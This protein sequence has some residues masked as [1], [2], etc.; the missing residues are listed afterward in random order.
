MF[1]FSGVPPRLP[2]EKSLI[3]ITEFIKGRHKLTRKDEELRLRCPEH[4]HECFK[5]NSDGYV[6]KKHGRMNC[7]RKEGNEVVCH[8]FGTTELWYQVPKFPE[9]LEDVLH[10]IALEYPPPPNATVICRP[11]PMEYGT[12]EE[13]GEEEDEHP[14]APL[15]PQG[16]R[17][18]EVAEVML[19][20][21]SKQNSPRTS[22]QT[23]TSQSEGEKENWITVTSK[24]PKR[25]A[26]SPAGVGTPNPF[27]PIAG[28]MEKKVRFY[29]SPIMKEQ[30][31][32]REIIIQPRNASP[33]TPSPLA[34]FGPRG[35]PESK[36]ATNTPIRIMQRSETHQA[37][38][39]EVDN[40][41]G[42]LQQSGIAERRTEHNKE[43]TSQQAGDTK[44]GK[45]DMANTNSMAR[46]QPKERQWMEAGEKQATRDE[47]DNSNQSTQQAGIVGRRAEYNKERAPQQTMGIKRTVITPREE[48]IAS[49]S[50]TM[51][52]QT[53]ERQPLNAEEKNDNHNKGKSKRTSR[54]LEYNDSN[55]NMIYAGKDPRKR[56]MW[57][58]YISQL[59]KGARDFIRGA[60]VADGLNREHLGDIQFMG[61]NI[62]ILT[63]PKDKASE[64][65]MKL[66]EIGRKRNFQPLP[67]DFDPTDISEIKK[68]PKYQGMSDAEITTIVIK[69]AIERFNRQAVRLPENRTGMKNYYRGQAKIM[70]KR[71]RMV[72]EGQLNHPREVTM[73]DF[74]PQVI[75]EAQQQQQDQCSQS[76][77]EMEVDRFED[78]I[79]GESNII[80]EQN[81]NPL[82]LTQ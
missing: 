66:K 33:K 18:Q 56:E 68:L 29:E 21:E 62:T 47:V 65:L 36:K 31:E 37:I 75:Q 59:K 10:W 61:K 13:L 11:C 25:V 48:D 67:L 39:A 74:L 71:L 14:N 57:Q 52:S 51:R 63:V 19:A 41:N 44:S 82:T 38:R 34:S 35:H 46:R 60:L 22:R 17:Y 28:R 32:L 79:E 27:Q 53:K 5:I 16:L 42:P 1:F 49:A 24:G 50:S 64:M 30:E 80:H 4:F 81:N 72:E 45:E 2:N 6:D 15:S 70:E 8:S 40:T 55:L 3:A 76:E 69:Q 58:I 23:E 9:E 77:Q 7:F 73:A 12:D 20:E 43:R 78:P 54:R 26:T